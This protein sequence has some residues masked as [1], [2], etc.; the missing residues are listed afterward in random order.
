MNAYFSGR[1]KKDEIS[2][3]LKASGSIYAALYQDAYPD[4][5]DVPERWYALMQ[6]A[7][8]LNSAPS[9]E[10]AAAI[11]NWGIPALKT[12]KERE[13]LARF[14]FAEDPQTAG[15]SLRSGVAYDE[16]R[17]DLHVFSTVSEVTH[18]IASLDIGRGHLVLPRTCQCE[19]FPA[20]FAHAERTPARQREPA[21]S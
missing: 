2:A 7:G 8:P 20:A 1:M 21:V 14:L 18:F 3:G 6:K 11:V 12:A 19:L 16:K 4:I 15:V 9:A 17:V 13:E 5:E 10:E